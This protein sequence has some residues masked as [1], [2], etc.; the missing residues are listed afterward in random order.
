MD[1]Q[2]IL[3]LKRV[4][5][6]IIFSPIILSVFYFYSCSMILIFGGN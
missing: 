2:D 1:R 3:L 4:R 6:G 5:A